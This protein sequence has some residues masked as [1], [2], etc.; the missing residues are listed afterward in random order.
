[1]K[2][3]QQLPTLIVPQLGSFLMGR[4]GEEES[5]FS[6]FVLLVSRNKTI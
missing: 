4:K 1:M 5:N 6:F 2:K 3:I